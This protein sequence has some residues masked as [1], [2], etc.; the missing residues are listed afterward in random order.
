M[1]AYAVLRYTAGIVN[2]TRDELE[3]MGRR[4][5]KMFTA[6]GGFHHKSDVDRL[7]TQ[8]IVG[9]RGLTSIEDVGYVLYVK[10]RSTFLSMLHLVL[11]NSCR[12]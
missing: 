5:R 7:Y 12:Q 3:T 1:R 9:G 4:S 6:H 8:R 10:K 2:R 11:T